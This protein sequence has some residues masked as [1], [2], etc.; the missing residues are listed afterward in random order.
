MNY[1]QPVDEPKI[2][3][4]RNLILNEK[5]KHLVSAMATNHLARNFKSWNADLINGKG[6]GKV[7]LLH[8]N[9]LGR[10]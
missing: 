5:T 6:E 3:P 7:V 8:G 2:S 1:V 9:F 10:F 4:M